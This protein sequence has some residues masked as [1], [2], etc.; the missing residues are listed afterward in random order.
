VRSR[1]EA[2]GTPR[3]QTVTH[4]GQTGA[5]KGRILQVD[6]YAGGTALVRSEVNLWGSR[7]AGANRYQI[8]LSENRRT[9]WDLVASGNPQFVTMV[10]DPPDAYGNVTHFYSS[11]MSNAARVD[12]YTTYAAPQSGSA[13][14]DRPSSVRTADASGTLE[15]K[16]FYYD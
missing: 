2:G 6:T 5:I 10:S 7:S 9:Q 8:W 4:F 15:E 16:W 1:V 13:V 11:G 3:N 12:T 14:Y